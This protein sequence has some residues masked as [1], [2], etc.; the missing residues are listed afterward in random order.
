MHQIFLNL[1][2]VDS[3]VVHHMA[4]N[5]FNIIVVVKLSQEICKLFTLSKL[6]VD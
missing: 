2:F 4:T 5:A 3:P 1:A 6:F